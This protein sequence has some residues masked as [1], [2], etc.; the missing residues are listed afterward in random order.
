M[1][2]EAKLLLRL[3]NRQRNSINQAIYQEINF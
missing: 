3:R 2:D 1:V